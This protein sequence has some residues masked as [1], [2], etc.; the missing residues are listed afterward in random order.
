MSHSSSRGAPGGTL[1]NKVRD[2]DLGRASPST[3]EIR[4]PSRSILIVKV[5]DGPRGSMA[6][7]D[8]CAGCYVFIKG[9]RNFSLSSIESRLRFIR[10]NR[11][12]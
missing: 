8:H 7:V 5:P 10:T 4:S 3:S 2:G 1:S 6:T 12:Y 11:P 9:K